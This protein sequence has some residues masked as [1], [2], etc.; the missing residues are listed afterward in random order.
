[1]DTIASKPRPSLLTRIDQGVF[2]VDGAMGTSLQQ[3][4]LQVEDFRGLDGCNELLVETRPDVV[5]GI[6]ASFLNVGCDAVETNTFGAFSVVLDEY[7]IGERAHALN[8][9]AAQIA[10]EAV[11]AVEA[12]S[13][14]AKPRYVLGSVGPGTKLPTLGHIGYRD[15]RDAY[16]PQML[17]LIEG[18]V[19][20]IQIETCQDLLQVKAA[21][22]AAR[23]AFV[24]LG[25]ELPLLVSITIESNGAM[26][27]GT[28]VQAAAAALRPLG[29]DV[30]G[31]NCATGP[32]EMARHVETLTRYGPARLLAM[33][34][35]GLPQNVDG[36]LVYPMSA[37][38]YADKVA[39][40]VLDHGVGIVGGCCGT[41]PKHL[42]AVVA[43]VGG[44]PAP[45]RE[46][47]RDA[48]VASLYQ[49]VSLR[50]A[51][52][53]LIVGERCNATGSK[54]FRERMLEDDL[55]GM[56]AIARKQEQTGAHVLD[57]SVAY[58]GR[59][60]SADMDRF[61]ARL[62]R[63]SRLP[64][65][66][67]STSVEVLETALQRI[68]GRAIINSIN[69]E[70]GEA[71][72]D[73]LAVLARRFGAAV[74]ALVIDEQGMAL[75]AERKLAVAERI[76]RRCVD[77]HGL[78]ES[79]IILDMLTFTVASG[80]ASTKRAAIDTLDAIQEIKRRHPEVHCLL[81]VSNVSFGLKPALRRVLNSVFLH[82]A[83]GRGLDA[84]ILN[85]LH[86][87][88]LNRIDDERLQAAGRLLFDDDSAGEPLSTYMALF[89][90]GSAG[91]G[92]A[93]GTGSMDAE[94]R[95]SLPADQ[96]VRQA[97]I[98]GV[99]QGL[100]ARLD[101]LLADGVAPSAI[102]NKILIDAMRE[103]GELFGAGVMQLPFVLQSAEVMKAAV[104][105][106]EPHIEAD[107]AMGKG[108]GLIK[109]GAVVLAT[110]KGDVH[111][112]GKNL[113]DI[114]LSN[115]G[116]EVV[117]LGVKVLIDDMLAAVEEH[118]AVALG[119]SG[120]LVKSTV[121]MKSNVE[122]MKRRGFE[123]PVLVGGAALA[124][125]Y[126]RSALSPAY[127]HEVHYAAT[128]I[129]ALGILEGALAPPA[130]DG[131]TSAPKAASKP[132]KRAA[133]GAA[134]APAESSRRSDIR[135]LE[136]PPVPPF[137]G[138]RIHEHIPL[139]EV[140]PLLDTRGLFRGRW[141]YRQGKLDAQ[142]YERLLADEVR[143]A[144]ERLTTELKADPACSVRCVYGWFPVRADL[145]GLD[146]CDPRAGRDSVDVIG[147]F[148]F[149]RKASAPYLSLADY[150]SG[151]GDSSDG[152]A[153]T[154][155]MFVTSISPA[156]VDRVR[157][158]FEADRYRDY[159]HLSGLAV[160]TAEACAEWIHARMRGEIGIGAEQG[161]R[162]SFGYPSAP[163]LELQRELFRLLDAERI[164]VVLSDELQM[165]PEQSVSAMVVH[166]PDAGPFTLD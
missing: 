15:L 38:A 109:R 141:R 137:F 24:T 95:A 10:R 120:L 26:L 3:A 161:F 115:N 14:D 128:A 52:A 86:L 27:M 40:F 37:E 82:E 107:A 103:V 99:K 45:R 83:V 126:V 55:D 157:E 30:L 80:D 2:I 90:D 53:P 125:S 46:A 133:S 102:I 138:T 104:A 73:Q 106:L 41:E 165:L 35:A 60:E 50:Q 18:G 25:S 118:G 19:D 163:D 59:D 5:R 148:P 89:D 159:L 162:Y 48:E 34:N 7:G 43:R 131:V 47:C 74:V 127:G 158:A 88:P 62:V 12:E 31:F 154:M 81:G 44:A 64:L 140:F 93:T 160:E 149:P 100:H 91:T 49:A 71:R 29:I 20:A 152:G 121:L 13:P 36:E 136:T 79:D 6:H 58:V 119:M 123:L 57:V 164:G 16:L 96:A 146:V 69:F 32:E 97:L 135:P 151:P 129:D 1:M 65:V 51:P 132:K 22:E 147:R 108:E 68:G 63:E 76:I 8:L 21:I 4:D 144:L 77:L 66:I 156:I 92:G 130:G 166:H 87:L 110:V 139:G 33:P 9:R 114:I 111:D 85:A 113:V 122:E 153:D 61:V 94:E 124:R 98:D 150:F 72:F 70:D 67:D 105:Y 75:E 23:Q 143:P 54:K 56:V 145:D 17:G 39:S 78:A 155:G 116:Y 101:D 42:A 142:A 84:A 28:D 117:N 112:I 134:P 11:Q